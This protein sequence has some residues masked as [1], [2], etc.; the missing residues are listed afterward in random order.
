MKSKK[1]QTSDIKCHR[2]G[3]EVTEQEKRRNGVRKKRKRQYTT[4]K[5]TEGRPRER[6]EE[7]KRHGVCKKRKRTIIY[8][9]LIGHHRKDLNFTR[10]S[11]TYP[12]SVNPLV[13]DTTLVNTSGITIPYPSSNE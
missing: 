5:E 12:I 7:K 11:G 13:Q 10:D 2:I 1:K 8:K 4:R 6:K 9:K 3:L